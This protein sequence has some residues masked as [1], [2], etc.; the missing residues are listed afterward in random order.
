MDDYYDDY[1]E[2]LSL[3]RAHFKILFEITTFYVYR[4]NINI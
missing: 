2:S 3:K 1:L 4:F